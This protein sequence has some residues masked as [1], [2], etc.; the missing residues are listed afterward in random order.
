MGRKNSIIVG[1]VITILVIVGLVYWFSLSIPS[2]AEI[3]SATKEISIP[4]RNI[5]SDKSL[6]KIGQMNI[7]GNLPIDLNA[8]TLGINNPFD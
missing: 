1:I 4:N 5:L 6:E 2:K 7:N 3:E 8:Q